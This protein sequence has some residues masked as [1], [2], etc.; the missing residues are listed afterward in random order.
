MSENMASCAETQ[1]CIWTTLR[2][3]DSG[4]VDRAAE[5]EPKGAMVEFVQVGMSCRRLAG[6]R[7]VRS[8]VDFS[9]LRPR[10]SCPFFEGLTGT[11]C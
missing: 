2:V 9:R 10:T 5:V 1:S 6:C 8:R 4:E 11:P 7:P 3:L